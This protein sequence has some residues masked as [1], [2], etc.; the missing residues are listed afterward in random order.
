[1]LWGKN[2]AHTVQAWADLASERCY[3]IHQKILSKKQLLA[4]TVDK[5]NLKY[6]HREHPFQRSSVFGLSLNIFLVKPG[7]GWRF[8]CFGLGFFHKVAVGPNLSLLPVNKTFCY[9]TLTFLPSPCHYPCT[10]WPRYAERL[11]FSKLNNNPSVQL[12][13]VYLQLSLS[14]FPR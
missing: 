2:L 1:M 11:T 8:F 7:L 12:D 9:R 4:F 10:L 3:D 14:L 13:S 6:M 5:A